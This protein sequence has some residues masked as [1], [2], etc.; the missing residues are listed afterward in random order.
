[1]A[2]NFNL[3]SNQ[4]PTLL[5]ASPLKEILTI[6]EAAEFLCVEKL[7]LQ[8]DERTG[9]PYYKPTANGVTS[10]EAN[11]KHGFSPE[12]SRRNLK[13]RNGRM[14]IASSTRK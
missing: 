11:L 12:E 5:P 9:N 13:S 14:P 8:A 10:S 7:P 6:E 2:D 1:M 3:Q 4:Q